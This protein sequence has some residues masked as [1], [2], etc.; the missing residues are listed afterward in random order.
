MI[1]NNDPISQ[2]SVPYKWP[3]KGKGIYPGHNLYGGLLIKPAQ[4]QYVTEIVAVPNAGPRTGGGGGSF[5]GLLSSVTLASFL[6]LS[7]M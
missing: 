7:I 4:G 5:I 1:D 2:P 3:N 6:V